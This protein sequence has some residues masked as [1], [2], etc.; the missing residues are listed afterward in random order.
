MKTP[1]ESI[2]EIL[3]NSYN[4]DYLNEMLNTE[5]GVII[6]TYFEAIKDEGRYCGDYDKAMHDAIRYFNNTYGKI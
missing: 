1:I 6:N 3:G 2:I 5:R 4:K